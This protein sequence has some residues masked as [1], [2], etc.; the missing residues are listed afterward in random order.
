MKKLVKIDLPFYK[1]SIKV[2]RPK[3]NLRNLRNDEDNYE[4]EIQQFNGYDLTLS[5]LNGVVVENSKYFISVFLLLRL[6]F[7]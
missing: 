4:N 6:I 5:C 2:Y 1:K 7:L 3:N